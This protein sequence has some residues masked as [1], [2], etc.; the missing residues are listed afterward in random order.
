MLRRTFLSLV[1][2]S[3]AAPLLAQPPDRA[4]P[5]Q[6]GSPRPL[7]LPAVQKR[8]LSNGIPIWSVQLDK[9]PVVQVSLLVFAGAGTDPAGKFGVASMTASMLDEGAASR[10]SLEIADAV[11]YLGA[12]LSTTIGYDSS[13]VR[14]WVPSARLKEALPIMADV[15]LRPTFPTSELERLR[16]EQLTSMA[17]MRDD[18]RSVASLALPRI[19]FGSDHRYGVPTFGTPASVQA[20]TVADLKAYYAANYRPSNAAIVVV[21]AVSADE[22]L[23]LLESAFGAWKG[24]T[25]GPGAGAAV[26]PSAK[27]PTARQVYIIDKPGAPQSQIFIGDIGVAR[28]TP[29]YFPI[30]AMNTILGG[31]FGSRLNNNLREKHGYTYG[32]GSSFSMRRA[33]G[34]FSATAGVQTEVTADALREFFNEF[35]AIQKPVPEPELMRGKNY[36]ALGFP[37]EFETTGQISAKLEELLAYKL[38]DTY[39]TT[40]V[41]NLQAV[42]SAQVQRAARDHI[43]PARFAVVIVGDR[44]AIETPVRTLNLG[45]VKVMSVDEALAK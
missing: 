44:K 20:F 6:V 7:R 4:Q 13:A 8:A 40:Y 27:R 2:F 39:Y 19:L 37:S 43:V 30:E 41:Q 23:S 31:S 33:P 14:L 18:P 29:D 9:V 26:P 3:I 35:G 16:K 22:A 45:P 17:Q 28:S 1:A 34:P 10:S 15:A 5:P 42:T 21:G 11:D 38:P 36:L 24:D 25:T 12:T 32:A